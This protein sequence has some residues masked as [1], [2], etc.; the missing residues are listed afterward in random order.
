LTPGE[1]VMLLYWLPREPSTPRIAMWRRLKRL[2]VGQLGDGLVA[3]PHDK[4]TREQLDW[5]A[6]QVIEAGGTA[7]TWLARPTMPPAGEALAAQL[8]TARAEE[9]RQVLAEAEFATGLEPAA[10][11]AALRRLRE[12]LHRIGRRDYF[13]PPERDAARA[14]VAALARNDQEVATA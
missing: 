6:E 8:A 2:G 1:W 13:P 9:Y 12:E 11:R 14:A 10:R 3:L 4:R 5:L 7:T